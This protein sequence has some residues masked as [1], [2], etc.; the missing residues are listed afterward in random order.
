MVVR[1]GYRYLTRAKEARIC[2][3]G[4]EEDGGMDS[5]KRK[6]TTETGQRDLSEAGAGQIVYQHCYDSGK[7]NLIY[8]SGALRI[9]DI[10]VVC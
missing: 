6:D 1:E 4:R 3:C 9:P 5:R 8:T 7:D 10:T 2:R